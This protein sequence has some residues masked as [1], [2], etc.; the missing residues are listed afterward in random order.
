MDTENMQI[1]DI[2]RPTSEKEELSTLLHISQGKM[3]SM[4][5][6]G[7]ERTIQILSVT[8]SLLN[9]CEESS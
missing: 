5:R 7:K 3:L 8:H 2:S 6:S 4:M 1:I 9:K